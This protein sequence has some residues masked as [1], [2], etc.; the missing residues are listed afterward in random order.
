[1]STIPDGDAQFLAD[2]RVA[3]V[4]KLGGVTKR[5]A[6]QLVRQSGG[7]AVDKLTGDVDLVV[8]GADE[9]PLLDQDE[10][11]DENTRRAA[12]E[13][14]L[15]IISET[16]LWQRLGLVENEQNVRR[17]YTPAML[18]ELLGVS[19]ATI[20]R[21]H[22]RGLIVPA[23]E[24]R[25]LPYFDFQEVATAQR[26]AQL[27][28]AGASPAA[29]E[30]QLAELSRYVP[31]VERPLAQL[32]VI[33]EGR[34]LLL[35]QGE[36]LIEP[37]GQLRFDFEALEQNDRD[38]GI[39]R[40]PTVSLEEYLAESVEPPSADELLAYAAELEDAGHLEQAAEMI[41]VVLSAVGPLPE[42][43]FQ[44]A[45]LLYR[46]G[47]LSAARERYY[48]A[49]ELDENFVEARANWAASWPNWGSSNWPS[50]RSKAPCVIMATTRTSITTWPA[51][52]T[53]WAA[54][55][56]PIGIGTVSW[57]W[58]R[59]A[60]GPTKRGCGCNRTTRPRPC[61]EP[62]RRPRQEFIR[63]PQL[64]RRRSGTR[65]FLPGLRRQRRFRLGGHRLGRRRGRRRRLR[66]RRLPPPG[67]PR[68]RRARHAPATLA[69]RDRRDRPAAVPGLC[70]DDRHGVLTRPFW[71]RVMDARCLSRF[72]T[73][74]LRVMDARCLSHFRTY[75]RSSDAATFQPSTIGNRQHADRRFPLR[76]RAGRASD[77]SGL[78]LGGEISGRQGNRWGRRGHLLCRFRLGR[79]GQRV[80]TGRESGCDR[81][82]E[83]RS[84]S[85]SSSRC[86]G[87]PCE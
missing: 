41:R 74:W 63:L 27:L 46:L 69:R 10:L 38:D 26:L 16:V 19:V 51:R 80:D 18:A 36:G 40:R 23:R 9:L 14:R 70:P 2:K 73:F 1:M 79:V 86:W 47:D 20:R 55:T 4:G 22:R 13:G 5:E 57:N 65:R 72:R 82:G 85:G 56:T 50:L 24:V 87:G 43:C 68:T 64:R 30:R 8:V 35:R 84:R 33:V 66:L 62:Y 61:D 44:L 49:I 39:V 7:I 76:P 53:T 32:S 17:L 59:T 54:A 25:R 52:W 71:L 21:W 12:A 42:L 58:R 31:E 28:A 29:I 34:R 83:E 67:I 75:D 81:H 15:E 78:G 6:Q 45:E 48:M 3:F 77:R 11:L 37:G 60:P